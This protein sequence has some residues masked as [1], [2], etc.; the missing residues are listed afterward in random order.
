M[1][2]FGALT[3]LDIRSSRTQDFVA[4]GELCESTHEACCFFC[5][6]LVGSG[7]FAKQRH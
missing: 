1:A 3:L 4:V 7:D 6:L 2:C 5:T